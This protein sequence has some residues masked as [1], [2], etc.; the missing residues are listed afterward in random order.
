M[1][2]VSISKFLLRLKNNC[3]VHASSPIYARTAKTCLTTSLESFEMS[4]ELGSEAMAYRNLDK[5]KITA[6]RPIDIRGLKCVLKV[7][8]GVDCARK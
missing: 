8:I 5:M 2:S 3:V 1:L 6:S 7:F 4:K